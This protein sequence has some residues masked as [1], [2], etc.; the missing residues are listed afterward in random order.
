VPDSFRSR[1][2]DGSLR[3]DYRQLSVLYW[4]AR[5]SN[6]LN[7]ARSHLMTERGFAP[8]E[9]WEHDLPFDGNER[10]SLGARP[11]KL[12]AFLKLES[13]PLKLDWDKEANWALFDPNELQKF[14]QRKEG[15]MKKRRGKILKRLCCSSCY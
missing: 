5:E 10:D 2:G 9:K 15:F 13:A 4:A 1:I 3:A 6:V 14:A 8:R 11:E 7:R 12:A